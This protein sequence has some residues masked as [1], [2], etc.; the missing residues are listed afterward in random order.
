VPAIGL[1]D[2]FD[3]IPSLNADPGGGH[4]RV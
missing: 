4:T 1:W 3:Y 2:M